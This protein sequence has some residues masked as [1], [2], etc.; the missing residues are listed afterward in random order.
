MF[1]NHF[2]VLMLK[3]IFKKKKK[4]ILMYFEMRRHFK[5]Q[6]LPHS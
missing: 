2:D 4:I 1:S 5:K 6:L 3:L